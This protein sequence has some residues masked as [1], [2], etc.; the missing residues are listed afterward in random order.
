VANGEHCVEGLRS[1]LIHRFRSMPG[2][3][4]ADF[5][6]HS[7]RFRTH[8]ARFGARALHV[9]QI[10]RIVTQEPF[11]H[12]APRRIAGAEDQDSL[13]IRHAP[14]LEELAQDGCGAIVPESSGGA[15][16]ALCALYAPAPASETTSRLRMR[17]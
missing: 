7:D 16:R 12:L 9:I 15:R 14:S 10:A 6:H 4:D 1:K 8:D 11:R 17:P 5:L 3:I 13:L 2:D